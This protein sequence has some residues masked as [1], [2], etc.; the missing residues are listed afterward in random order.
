M[1]F[2]RFVFTSTINDIIDN[3][4]SGESASSTIIEGIPNKKLRRIITNILPDIEIKIKRDYFTNL[5]K[6]RK[7]DQTKYDERLITSI[8]KELNKTN[9]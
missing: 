2:Q 6:K 3:I 9:K 8:L 7:N 5:F 1:N 4:I